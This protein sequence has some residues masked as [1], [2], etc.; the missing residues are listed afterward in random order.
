MQDDLT[1][2]YYTANVL[3]DHFWDATKKV[4]I[5]AIGNTA[6]V[7]VSQ[8]PVGDFG[9]NICVGDIGRSH[10]NIYRQ[11]LEGAKAAKTKYIALAEDDVL[12][13]G[14]HFRYRPSKPGIF[15]YN[16][17]N[18]SIYTWSEPP[19]FSYKDRRN[20]YSLICERDL[21]IASMEERFK[22]YHDEEYWG[23]EFFV[24]YWAEPGKYEG[25]QH[26]GVTPQKTE[27]FYSEPPIIA[28]S[29]PTGLSFR[30]LGKR[31]RIGHLQSFEIPYWNRAEDVLKLYTG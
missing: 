25:H 9:Y 28:F 18:W 15:A 2:V 19:V 29:H 31:K 5:E 17:S 23:E 4:L 10:L 14:D 30:G 13:S 6:I 1:V 21:F 16:K 24:K 27:D 11:A 22:K 26:L 3:E 12:Y 8:K 20:L 7:S